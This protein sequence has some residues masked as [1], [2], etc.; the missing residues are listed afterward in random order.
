MLKNYP[1][2]LIQLS[3]MGFG[4]IALYSEVLSETVRK[5]VPV[6]SA[7]KLKKAVKEA[8]SDDD[9]SRNVVL[10]GLS[11]NESADLEN[12]IT[13]LFNVIDEKPSFEAERIGLHSEE[14]KSRPVKVSFRNA[15]TVHRILTKA[16]NLRN[17]ADY[18]KVYNSPDRT[19]E[20]RAKH[21]QLVAEMRQLAADNPGQ[22]FF[23]HCGEICKREK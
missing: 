23:I 22:H 17:S 20:E 6:L 4:L 7:T 12:Q 18:R 14:E 5:S 13:D 10:F 2:S 8:V 15:E 19:P 1:L 21:R 11:E 16:M 3:R 9:R